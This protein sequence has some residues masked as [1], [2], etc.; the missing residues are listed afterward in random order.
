MTDQLKI[1]LAQ[2]NPILGNIAGNIQLAK[3]FREEAESLGA[4]LVVYPE[5]FL[6]GY[7][8]EDLVLKPAFQRAAQAA[9]N[10]L[11]ELTLDGGPAMLMSAPL[12]EDSKLYNAVCLLEDGKVSAMRFKN[13]LPNYGVFDEMRV[14]ESGP[15]PGPIPFKGVRLGVMICEDMWFS[16][17]AECLEETGAEILIVPNGSPYDHNKSDERLNY[18][19]ERVSETGLPLIYVN[20]IGGQDELVFD[21]ASFVL[22]T[23]RSLP[24]QMASWKEGLVVTDWQR[25]ESDG[26]SCATTEIIDPGTSLERMYHAMVLGL[27]DYVEKNR[28]P[29][30]VLGL[31][32]GIDSALSAAVAVDALGPDRVHCV[33]MPSK[34][35]SPESLDD[36]AECAR[37]LGTR[38]DTISI[39]PAVD[40]FDV[41]LKDV[42]EGQEPDITEENIQSRARGMALM[43]LSNKLGSMVLTTGN[44]SEMSVGYATLYGDMCGGYSVLKDVYK[45]I[46]FDLSDWRN[47]HYSP[48]FKGPDG[49]VMPQNVISKPPTA[50]LRENQK[51]E[52]SLP[53]YDILDGILS[54]LVEEEKSFAELVADG[55]EASTISRIQ[56]LLYIAEYKRRQSPPG[57]KIST[58]NFGRDRRYPITNGFRDNR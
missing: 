19:V 1:A 23:D 25:D 39:V 46:C 16:D 7:P 38:L 15:L 52:D 56:N 9:I 35:T 11:A 27:K 47:T 20:Q 22:N 33:M 28:F 50:E 51:D 5:L 45:T 34:Y 13:K 55:Y 32:G 18:A 43:A 54:G 30:V 37:L 36:A 42:F 12:M 14:F 17:V 48:V 29:G 44:K 41:M 10:E 40:A 58:R 26:W 2:A 31:S 4:D 3:E 53:P 8:P 24:V 57:V 6:S 49:A 21:G